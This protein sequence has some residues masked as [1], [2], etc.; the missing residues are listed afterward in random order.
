MIRRMGKRLLWL[1]LLGVL[2]CSP[3]NG[4]SMPSDNPVRILFIG[5]SYTYYNSLPR[6]VKAMAESRYSG[7]RFETRFAGR[8]GATLQ[9]LWEAGKAVKEIKTGHWDYV[10]LQEQSMLGTAVVE[11]GKRYF[12][13]PEPFFN[14][15]KKFAWII[16]SQGAEPVFFM[17]WSR[18]KHPEQQ[19]YLSYAYM[20]IARELD[21]KVAPVGMV[22][23]K[24]RNR[25]DTGLY[26]MDGS[27]PT[28]EG[29][30]LA[31][32]TLFAV[33]FDAS[34]VGL[35]GRLVGRRILRGGRI[36]D[37]QSVLCNLGDG[38]TKM[39][40]TAVADVVSRMRSND[41]YLDVKKAISPKRPSLMSHITGILTTAQ[42][43][44]LL[45]LV[46]VI[47]YLGIK[48]FS[49]YRQLVQG[50]ST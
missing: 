23:D 22:W 2:S 9:E 19:K 47:I 3:G 25:P 39:I 14:Y 46:A 11:D 43:Q 8:G 29:S 50:E 6:M 35:P 5:N 45:L 38:K 13:S 33:L 41:G 36:S 42:G 37:E 21:S 34:P 1:I 20:H 40:Q 18:Q 10:V 31:A 32:G 48:G 15:A 4:Q 30:Y 7:R 27:H 17:T 24:V 49:R 16:K 44:A 12:G 28:V 26:Q